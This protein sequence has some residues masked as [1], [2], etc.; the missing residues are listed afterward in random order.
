MLL[1]GTLLLLLSLLLMEEVE[2]DG[3]GVDLGTGD[4]RDVPIHI[5]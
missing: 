5:R 3:N 4:Y 2:V 1:G